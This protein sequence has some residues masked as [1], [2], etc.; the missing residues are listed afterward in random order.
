MLRPRW[1][2]CVTGVSDEQLQAHGLAKRLAQ[3]AVMVLY[4]LGGKALGSF[5]V[6]LAADAAV[7]VR[8]GV[9]ALDVD[10]R[11]R[12]GVREPGSL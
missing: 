2:N 10:R 11:R 1:I 9:I 6:L 12:V 3:D 5:R 4:G 8:F 7:F